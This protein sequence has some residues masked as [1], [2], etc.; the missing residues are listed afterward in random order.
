MQDSTGTT[1]PTFKSIAALASIDPVVQAAL[2]FKVAAN[3][4][5]EQ[6]LAVLVDALLKQRRELTT[7]AL[8]YANRS[9]PRVQVF[10]PS[11][12]D[13][14]DDLKAKL[15]EMDPPKTRPACGYWAGGTMECRGDG[16]LWDADHDG[17]DPDDHTYPCPQCNTLEF[18]WSAS[19][20]A[21][22][23]SFFTNMAG[24]GTGDDIWR[25]AVAHALKINRDAAVAA[26]I[27]IH[28]VTT[29]KGDRN[30]MDTPDI[31]ITY[32]YPN[33]E[34]IE[35]QHAKARP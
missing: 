13:L 21:S 16:Y 12:S 15:A 17:Y 4:S 6:T 14:P 10:D 3:L 35:L 34:S 11:D 9:I 26:L 18:L 32:V 23:T 7:L 33:P 2:A 5:Q 29:L 27:T 8:D 20:S 24:S 25:N 19:E 22:T 30:N 28:R 1:L 31:E